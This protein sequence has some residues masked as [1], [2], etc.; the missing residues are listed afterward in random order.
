MSPMPTFKIAVPKIIFPQ[1]YREP[2]GQP[3]DWEQEESGLLADAIAAWGESRD[4]T[5]NQYRVL[6][7]YIL[8][9]L[10]APCW[11]QAGLYDLR[12]LSLTMTNVSEM[13]SVL[14]RAFKLGI[15]PW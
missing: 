11:E 4:L 12:S 6:K 8:Y 3:Y 7:G 2:F 13:E 9:C 15:K 14:D 1:F 5:Q 10:F